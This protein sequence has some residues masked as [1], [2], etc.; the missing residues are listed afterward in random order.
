MRWIVETMREM[1]SQ[2][3]PLEMRNAY[4]K[5][6]RQLRPTDRTIS[7]SRRDLAWPRYRVTRSSTWTENINP[8]K[9]KERLPLLQGGLFAELIYGDEPRLFDDLSVS[10]DDPAAK[11][12]EDMRSMVAIPMF[13]QGVS[14]NMI[15]LMRREPN[16]FNP[17]DMPELVQVSNLFGRATH[18]LVLMDELKAAYATVDYEMRRVAEIQRSLLPAFVPK[19][20]TLGLAAYYQTSDQAGGDYYDF[21]AL[22]DGKWGII[23]ADVS[24]H[25]TPAAVIMAVTHSLAHTHP[26]PADTPSGL[27]H[28]VNR[29]LCELYT[30][31]HDTFVTAFYCIY[32]PAERSLV[33]ACA[34]HNPPRLK[35]CRDGSLDLLDVARGLPMGVSPIET[36]QEAKYQLMAGDQ[37][38]LY[39]DGVT[40]ALNA[41]G[42]Q[43]GMERLDKVLENCSIAASDLLQAVLAA[44]EEFTAAR[45]AHDDRTLLVAKVT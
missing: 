14:L 31:A 5:R 35:R 38:V 12:V 32:D 24:G 20:P 40:E 45:P 33:Y 41:K 37:L 34:G 22:P 13:D 39:T 25:G 1:S 8:W 27:L 15:L 29:Y 2:T 26:G 43:F 9:E 6:M 23:I 42:E 11:Y 28:H 3:D 17:E 21:F 36:Y 16:A 10:P 18:N 4:G 44:V 19:I 30:S 7:L